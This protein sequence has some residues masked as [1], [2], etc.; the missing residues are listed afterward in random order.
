MVSP[1]HESRKQRA[2]R[3]IQR[4]GRK[5]VSANFSVKYALVFNPYR[6]PPDRALDVCMHF[7]SDDDS[8]NMFIHAGDFCDPATN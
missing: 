1:V 3:A 8:I 2:L 6:I 7:T 5:A 4:A